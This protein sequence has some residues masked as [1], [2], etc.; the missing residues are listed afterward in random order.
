MHEFSPLL[1]GT[2]LGVQSDFGL[3]AGDPNQNPTAPFEDEPEA[4]IAVHLLHLEAVDLFPLLFEA[5][6]V[7]GARALGERDLCTAEGVGADARGQGCAGCPGT[8]RRG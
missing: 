2:A 5:L 3:R 4:V 7:D 6:F 8:V 1:G